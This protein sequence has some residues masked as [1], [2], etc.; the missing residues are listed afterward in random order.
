MGAVAEHPQ[1]K[2][3]GRWRTIRTQNAEVRALLPPATFDDIEQRM[4]DVPALGQHTRS[5]LLEAGL[6]DATMEAMLKS[7]AALQWS[8]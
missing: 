1:L 8:A 2:A 5:V 4:G 3:R 6:D 7:G